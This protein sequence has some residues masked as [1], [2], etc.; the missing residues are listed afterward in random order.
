MKDKT[1]VWSN[2]LKKIDLYLIDSIFNGCIFDLCSNENNSTL[3]IELKCEAYEK[4]ADIC[5]DH[6]SLVS[7]RNITA[8]R[9]KSLKN[10]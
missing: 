4:L 5:I 8:C 2:C 3:L 6:T 10:K 7:W 9:I 1:G